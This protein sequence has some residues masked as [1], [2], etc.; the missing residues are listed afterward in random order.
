MISALNSFN[1]NSAPIQFGANDDK[2]DKADKIAALRRATAASEEAQTRLQEAQERFGK[3][4]PAQRAGI[5]GVVGIIL[6]AVASGKNQKPIVRTLALL[7]AAGLMGSAGLDL[8][9][10]QQNS[11]LLPKQLTFRD[12]PGMDSTQATAELR[13]SLEKRLEQLR[14]V[15]DGGATLEQRVQ[16]QMLILEAEAALAELDEAQARTALQ[17]QLEA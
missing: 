1:A 11:R 3:V 10:L 5:K 16:K 13:E 17:Q 15:K 12:I 2:T 9:R 6:L 4:T 14:G 7:A 8:L